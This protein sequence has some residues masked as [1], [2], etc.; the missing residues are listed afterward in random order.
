MIA[1]A[2]GIGM[3]V[4]FIFTEQ[5]G[6]YAGGLIVPG[7]MAFF[8]KQPFRIGISFLVALITYALVM[9][10]S[11]AI[12]LYGRRRFMAVV[13]V[14]YVTGWFVSLLIMKYL[15]IEQDFRV[16]GYIIPGLI[17]ND[18]IKQGIWRTI[19]AVAIVSSIVR[20]IVLLMMNN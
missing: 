20:L 18:M 8:W 16:I 7:Y 11:H 17:A 2:I 9:A 14:G 1:Q 5:V 13:L 10:L 3:I 6:L 15:P 19:L 4:S 12:I